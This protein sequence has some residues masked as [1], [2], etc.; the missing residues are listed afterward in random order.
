MQKQASAFAALC[1]GLVLAAC[2]GAAPASEAVGA[3][4]TPAPTQ[5]PAATPT[6]APSATP[7]LAPYAWPTTA[8]T[9]ENAAAV[10]LLDTWGQG[11]IIALKA[12]GDGQVFFA[13]TLTKLLFFDTETRELL[14]EM[15]KPTY[16][17]YSPSSQFMVGVDAA[18]V[19]SLGALGATNSSFTLESGEP[20]DNYRFVFSP[21][22]SLVAVARYPHGNV[23]PRFHVIRVYAT[24]SG[25]LVATLD[26]GD[27]SPVPERIVIAPGSQYLIV[28][29]GGYQ[30]VLGIWDIAEQRM[31]ARFLDRT[32]LPTNP[33]SPDGELFATFSENYL[34]L[35]SSK[36]G[37][38]AGRYGTGLGWTSD[39]QFSEDG[40]YVSINSGEQVRKASD[41]SLLPAQ[42]AEA[43][44]FPENSRPEAISLNLSS[45]KE[46]LEAQGYFGDRGLILPVQADALEV[47]M[48]AIDTR[49]LPI[50]NE[51]ASLSEIGFVEGQTHFSEDKYLSLKCQQGQL[52]VLSSNSVPV[53]TLAACSSQSPVAASLNGGLAALANGSVV[54]LYSLTDGALVATLRAHQ[55]DVQL[56]AF[57]EDGRLLASY[58]NK[59][60]F[61]WSL[62][63]EVSKTLSLSG[64]S[65]VYGPL[66]FSPDNQILMSNQGNGAMGVWRLTDGQKLRDIKNP[67]W[68]SAMAFLGE[69]LVVAVGSDGQLYLWDYLST[70][71]LT[72]LPT[73]LGQVSN[74]RV[75]LD[76]RGILIASTDGIL[77][78]WGLE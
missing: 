34:F 54:E 20:T 7:T 48:P 45:Q 67:S 49:W 74:T 72:T 16:F 47:W 76:G 14:F 22:E 10:T 68:A 9:L 42:E 55:E 40:A 29:D 21:D 5:P 23:H 41:G 46:W 8:I 39:V 77:Q 26:Q 31:I 30:Q 3:S 51:V 27:Y 75:V 37:Q 12:V 66:A 61:I 38:A 15:P 25:E 6:Q 52:S 65:Q 28:Q 13:E 43:I 44:V 33:F 53:Q 64:P 17:E 63:G 50:Q 32:L 18:G 69:P 56:L 71:L 70:S 78:L 73:G 11:A 60:F 35:W 19:V 36:T 57:S 4:A 59:E 62:E 1:C 2:A 58:A 24:S